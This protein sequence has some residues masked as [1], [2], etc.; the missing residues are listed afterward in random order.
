MLGVDAEQSDAI[1]PA[2]AYDHQ[3]FI[4]DGHQVADA[5][6]MIDMAAHGIDPPRRPYDED[7]LIPTQNLCSLGQRRAVG[8]HPILD[9]F[10][11]IAIDFGKFLPEGF[12]GPT[13]PVGHSFESCG[14]V[15]DRLKCACRK[16]LVQRWFF[17]PGMNQGFNFEQLRWSVETQ[18]TVRV[19]NDQIVERILRLVIF[20]LRRKVIDHFTQIFFL[21]GVVAIETGQR[22]SQGRGFD[23]VDTRVEQ[24]VA[25]DII[26]CL[27]DLCLCRGIKFKA[28]LFRRYEFENIRGGKITFFRG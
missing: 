27:N 10:R 4:A 9:N 1:V 23:E 26:R 25:L 19:L 3:A 20:D 18:Y 16:H 11:F 15:P 28:G 6:L 7:F 24:P 17:I 12:V 2:G 5:A 22:I 21:L 13:A 14:P 8:T